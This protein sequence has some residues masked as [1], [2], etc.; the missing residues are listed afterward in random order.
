MRR[1][2]RERGRAL[3]AALDALCDSLRGGASLRQALVDG[4]GERPSPLTP[5]ALAL[6]EGRPLVDTLRAA[7][8]SGGGTAVDRDL[9]AACCVLAVHAE[10]GGDPL[11][12][13]RSVAERIALRRAAADEARALTTQSRLGARTI[14]LLTPAFLGLVVLSDPRSVAGW[15]GDP[16]I[17]TA[18]V[19][20]LMLQAVGAWWIAAIVRRATGS[21][22]RAAGLPVLRAAAVLLTGRSAPT[23]D[24]D[25][26]SCAEIVALV[27][28]AGGSTTSALATVAPHA[29][30]RFGTVLREAVA[31]TD[32][33]I[34]EALGRLD[35]VDGEAA[36][37]F[38]RSV[39]AAT[40]LG[41]PLAP[42]MLALSNDVRERNRIRASED[43]RRASVRVLL[44][45]G[46][47]V[48]PAFVLACL[49]PLF[50]GGLSGL[51]GI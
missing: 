1:A 22:S 49:V 32:E 41:V 34:A 47:L 40:E 43:V 39:R 36:V 48:L 11:P 42:A 30:G 46:G 21:A 26:A 33:P 17:R 38:T 19:A 4:I 8:A 9:A 7:A 3:V 50:V 16:R 45:L 25:V 5:I 51:T 31:A 6:R 44:P 23:D 18:I 24:D 29:A 12:A 37:R 35:D 2:E 28:H 20:G 14:V 13:C 10:S 27:C 15:F